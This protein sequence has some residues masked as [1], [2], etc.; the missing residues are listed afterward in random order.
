MDEKESS[1]LLVFLLLIIDL[2]PN[3]TTF[4]V[5]V[6]GIVVLKN[7]PTQISTLANLI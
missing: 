5:K 4:Q 6:T 7:N 2:P 1:I 3:Y